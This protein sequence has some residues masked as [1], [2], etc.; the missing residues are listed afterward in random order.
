M[1]PKVLF[2]SPGVFDKGGISR[3]CRYQITALR[4]LLG[5]DAVE[6]MSLAPPRATDFETPFDASFASFG[7]TL[8]GR[9]VFAGAATLSTLALRPRIVWAAHVNLSPLALVLA[10]SVGARFALN[11]YGSEVW[12]GLSTLRRRAVQR[13]DHLLSDCYST[14]DHVIADGLHRRDGTSVHWD[15][16]DTARFYPAPANS[17]LERYGVPP[18][19]QV[20]TVLTLARLNAH[21]RHK[22]VDRLISAMGLLRD[23]AVR[24]VVAGGGTGVEGLKKLAADA[25]LSDRVHFTGRIA[26]ADLADLYR[27]CDVFSLITT[28]GIGQGEGLPLTPIEAAAC[29]KP[30]LV[31]TQDG[32]VEAVEHGVTGFA[33]DPLDLQATADHLRQLVRDERLRARLGEAG[34]LR[35]KNEMGYELFRERLRP[36]LAELLA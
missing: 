14:L 23:E 7:A 10:R 35:T 34:A 2:L 28:K 5:S 22:G 26:E 36:I 12:S 11:V 29:G 25:S 4:S 24:L 18:N 17:V 31:G 16:V 3:Y 33:L 15:C 19:P 1:P 20:R 6:V 8:R 9:G 30:I 27:S 21:E 32:S 13:A